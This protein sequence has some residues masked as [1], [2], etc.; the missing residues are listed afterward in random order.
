MFNFSQTTVARAVIGTV[1]TAFC[2]SVCLLAAAAPA[3]AEPVN[4]TRVVSYADLNLSTTAGRNVLANRIDQAAHAVCG[5]GGNADLAT[6]VEA[7]R[8]VRAAKASAQPSTIATT[9]EA[10]SG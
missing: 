3:A 2:A 9:T 5:A 8:C 6:W 7:N 1:G 10:V 4:Q